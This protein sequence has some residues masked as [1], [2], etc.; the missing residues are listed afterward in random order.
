MKLFSLTFLF[1]TSI[2]FSQEVSVFGAGDLESSNPY[3]LTSSERVI[4]IL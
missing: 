2:L 4:L 3:G 1:S